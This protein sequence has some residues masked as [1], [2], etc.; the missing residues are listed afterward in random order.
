MTTRASRFLA[1]GEVL[2]I[3]FGMLRLIGAVLMGSGLWEAAGSLQRNMLGHTLMMA[4]PIAWLLLTRRDLA[5]FG[6]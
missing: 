6:L 5:A 3:M 2:L 1:V 4:V